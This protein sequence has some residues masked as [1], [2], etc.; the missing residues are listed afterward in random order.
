MQNPG[1]LRVTTCARELVA[2]LYTA[3]T[4]FPVSEQFGLTA[5]MRRAA[6]SIGS[7]I[8]EGCG[9][10]GERELI[11]F[12]HLGWVQPVSSTFSSCC[13]S[14]WPFSHNRTRRHCSDEPATSSGCSLVSSSR[15]ARG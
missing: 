7:N 11:R 12:L 14:I 13:P 1:N 10:S 4:R 9:R 3:T 5:Q 6:V 8:A 15:C 2:E